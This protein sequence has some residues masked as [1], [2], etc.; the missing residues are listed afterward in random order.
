MFVALYEM[1]AKAGRENDF[2]KAW[3]EWTDAIHRVRGS[4]GSRLHKTEVPRVY[5]AYAQ[6]PSKE[7]YDR[8]GEGFT[9]TEKESS[10]RMF[11][12]AEAIK[13]LHLM[14][15]CNDRLKPSH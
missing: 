6:W 13:T 10:K 2:E 14:D 11:D 15:V 7:A 12:A 4:W 8:P 3:A 5:V 1:T 9:E